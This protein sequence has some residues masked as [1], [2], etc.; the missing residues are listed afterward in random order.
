MPT[1]RSSWKNRANTASPRGVSPGPL[2][3]SLT[4]PVKLRSQGDAAQ[5]PDGG[6]DERGLAGARRFVVGQQHDAAAALVGVEAEREGPGTVF[7]LVEHDAVES[8]AAGKLD[9]ARARADHNHHL[10]LGRQRRDVGGLRRQR[11]RLGDRHRLARHLGEGC[12]GTPKHG[13]QAFGLVG[14]EREADTALA[15]PEGFG[16]QPEE[17]PGLAAVDQPAETIEHQFALAR[18][19]L[20]LLRRR[21]QRQQQ[22]GEGERGQ[23]H[24]AASLG[25]A[26]PSL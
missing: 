12:G 10:R 8:A 16:R 5:R 20:A 17:G 2:S 23:P 24:S 3:E 9:E 26:A 1:S 11:R 4:S 21:R 19:R 25:T 7:E 15:P 18:R 6:E 22:H 14:E 13:N